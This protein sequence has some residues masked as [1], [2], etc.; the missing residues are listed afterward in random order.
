MFTFTA[1]SV[2]PPEEK[3]PTV[4]TSVTK[5]PVPTTTKPTTTT[6]ITRKPATTS[7][8]TAQ[9][10][11]SPIATAQGMWGVLDNSWIIVFST[12]EQIRGH[13]K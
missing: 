1:G 10:T 9:S 4:P 5:K 11:Q 8:Q 7:S 6:I 2:A 12:E 3:P 13:A